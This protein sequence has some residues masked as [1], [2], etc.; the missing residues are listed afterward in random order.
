MSVVFL[1]VR[2]THVASSWRC[3]TSRRIRNRFFW[4]RTRIATFI[5]HTD[6]AEPSRAVPA[7]CRWQHNRQIAQWHRNITIEPI[8]VASD[9]R[10]EH[11]GREPEHPTS[12][13]WIRN[14][15]GHAGYGRISRGKGRLDGSMPAVL[16]CRSHIKP[17]AETRSLCHEC[18][19]PAR[20]FKFGAQCGSAWDRQ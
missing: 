7:N 4:T 9:G 12:R 16:S 20:V 15:S 2:R 18:H 6:E 17:V 13:T 10:V 14:A 1:L 19:I 11:C 5:T 3:Q 8:S